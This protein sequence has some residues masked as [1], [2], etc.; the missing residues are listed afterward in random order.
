MYQRLKSVTI[1]T[2]KVYAPLPSIYLSSNKKKNKL[3]SNF[4]L[5]YQYKNNNYKYKVSCPKLNYKL[6]QNQ[7]AT[8]KRTK[9]SKMIE[10]ENEKWRVRREILINCFFNDVIYKRLITVFLH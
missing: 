2:Q 6:K 7:R 8:Y 9:W 10:N 5:D 3:V 1:L 4:Y